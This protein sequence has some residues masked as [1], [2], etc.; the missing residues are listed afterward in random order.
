MRLNNAAVST[1]GDAERFVEIDGRRY[2]HIV[3]PKTGLGVVDRASVT[4]VARDGATADALDTAV[5]AM[6]PSR[7]LPIV[8][9]TEGAAALIV[10]RIDVDG[11]TESVE[12]QT[13]RAVPVGPVDGLDARIQA[14]ALILSRDV[15]QNARPSGSTPRSGLDSE[16]R[17]FTMIR[18]LAFA[19]KVWA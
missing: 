9:A 8:E 13:A 2:S 11:R 5:Y 6:G 4:V 19:Q 10:R 3:D 18:W 17:R 7:G 1:A 12:V 15:E 16:G 14:P